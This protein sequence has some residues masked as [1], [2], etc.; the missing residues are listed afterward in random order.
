MKNINYIL[1]V[2]VVLVSVSASAKVLRTDEAAE[3]EYLI[4]HGHSDEIVRLIELQKKR[5]QPADESQVVEQEKGFWGKIWEAIKNSRATKFARNMF[6]EGDL[7]M[8]NEKFGED[9]VKTVESPRR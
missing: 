6:Y 2:L 3:E 1:I 8:P 7:T 9:R 4:K 5:L